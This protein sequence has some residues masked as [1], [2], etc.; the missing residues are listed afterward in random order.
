MSRLRRPIPP[1]RIPSRPGRWKLLIRRQRR[2]LRPAA[3][4]SILVIAGAVFVVGVNVMGSGPPLRERV[5]K[6]GAEIGMRVG[7]VVIE[8]REKT[9]ENLLRAAI[10]VS[11]GDPILSYSVTEARSRI[12][13]L[14]WVQHATVERR[15][16]NTILVHL[17]ERSPFAV[18]QT[19]GRFVLID[20]SGDMVTDSD[21]AS[22]SNELPLVVGVGAPQ[23]AASLIDAMARRPAVRDHL[24]AAVRVG[25]RRWNLRMK[26]G[27]DVLLPEGAEE[28][29]LAKLAEL[30]AQHQLLDRPLQIVDLRLPDRLVIRARSDSGVADRPATTQSPTARKPT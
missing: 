3:L 20:R 2:L 9:P 30:Q 25:D 11:R 22:F 27:T 23:A 6:I 18:W 29:A 21:V 12:E 16:P 24:V 17:V 14:T 1:P 19:Q 26:N 10:G 13:T 8:G 28:A 5:G 4:A 15:L 7:S